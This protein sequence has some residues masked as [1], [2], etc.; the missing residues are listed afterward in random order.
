MPHT[1]AVLPR[2]RDCLVDIA[3]H[4]E[5]RAEDAHGLAQRRAHHRFTDARD[6]A[7]Q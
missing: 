1:G 3:T 5:L 6:Q 4:D 2:T 7:L